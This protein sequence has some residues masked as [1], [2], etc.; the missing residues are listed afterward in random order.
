MITRAPSREKSHPTGEAKP[1]QGMAA[2]PRAWC[3]LPSC[4][5]IVCRSH[6]RPGLDRIGHILKVEAM[7]PTFGI[8]KHIAVAEY[9]IKIRQKQISEKNCFADYCWA[10][11]IC[12]FVS[13]VESSWLEAAA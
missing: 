11:A 1:V 8:Q 7:Q 9:G 12:V 6:V 13:V 5:P 2:H 4:I 10:T 3:R